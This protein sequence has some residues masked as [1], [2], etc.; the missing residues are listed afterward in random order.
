MNK[1]ES[2]HGNREIERSHA[3]NFVRGYREKVCLCIFVSQSIDTLLNVFFSKMLC[4]VV[5]CRCKKIKNI[6][7][8]I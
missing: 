4:S 6:K 8:M 3:G 5:A 1:Y 2:K 7:Q